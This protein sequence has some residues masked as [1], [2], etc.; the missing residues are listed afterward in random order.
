[1]AGV[2]KIVAG[3]KSLE[4][5]ESFKPLDPAKLLSKSPEATKTTEQSLGTIAKLM[6]KPDAAAALIKTEPSVI[7]RTAK[8]VDIT[9]GQYSKV[10]E[11]TK[12][13]VDVDPVAVWDEPAK[14][15][16]KE[17]LGTG[18]KG[19]GYAASVASGVKKLQS[20]DETAQLGGA[21]QTAGG[22]AGLVAMTNFWNPVGW[23]AAIPAVLSVG[24]SLMGGGGTDPFAKTPLGRYRRRVGIG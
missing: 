8:G 23:A 14:G 24:G 4:A 1:M 16:L 13:A 11:I 3:R 2:K 22:G 15:G 17:T 5:T 7:E 20:R 10:P 19:L 6:D 21:M 9:G 12:P 18:V